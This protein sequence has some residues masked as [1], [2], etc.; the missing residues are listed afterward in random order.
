MSRR[1]AESLAILK[2]RL[3]GDFANDEQQ[4]T[5]TGKSPSCFKSTR[6]L[7]AW[8]VLGLATGGC[9]FSLLTLLLSG[10]M[11]LQ[12]PRREE[13]FAGGAIFSNL[14]SRSELS[15]V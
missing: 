10:G 4:P 13:S 3:F 6:R 15:V 7:L 11:R 1:E 12:T 2:T 5:L 8:G 14:L 9:L